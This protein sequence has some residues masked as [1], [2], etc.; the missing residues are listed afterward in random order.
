VCVSVALVNQQAK[1]MRCI[2]IVTCELSGSNLFFH[3]I[4]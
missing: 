3:I 4:S 1:C 2:I